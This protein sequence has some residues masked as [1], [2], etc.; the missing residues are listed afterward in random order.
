MARYMRSK[1]LATAFPMALGVNGLLPRL[2]L[3][4]M[5]VLILS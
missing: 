2:L 3:A 5:A 1:L 4:A